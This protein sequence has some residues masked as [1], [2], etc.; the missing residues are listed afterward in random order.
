M[1][2]VDPIYFTFTE[3]QD[4]IYDF[5][6][7]SLYQNQEA[8]PSNPHTRLSQRTQV[9]LQLQR[10]PK[11]CSP[12]HC[13]IH[14][15]SNSSKPVKI[16]WAFSHVTQKMAQN[17]ANAAFNNA[18]GVLPETDLLTSRI[19]TS[20]SSSLSRQQFSQQN[21]KYSVNKSPHRKLPVAQIPSALVATR[22]SSLSRSVST[23]H[24][25]HSFIL[26]SIPFT[27]EP[28]KPLYQLHL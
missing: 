21:K 24:S 7:N 18:Q 15:S 3:S 12:P 1:I 8:A 16:V 2:Q 14:Q 27:E 13:S 10:N 19:L 26:G 17:P 23:L 22:E 6:S 4:R 25:C 9:P 20:S 11:I 5:L 28:T